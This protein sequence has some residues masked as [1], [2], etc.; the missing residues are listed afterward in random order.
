MLGLRQRGT[1]IALVV[2]AALVLSACARGSVESA[3]AEFSQEAETYLEAVAEISSD[4][5]TVVAS[6]DE[7]MQRVYATRQALLTAVADAGISGASQSALAQAEALTP[8]DEFETDHQAWIGHRVTIVDLA[9]ELDVALE[10]QDLQEALAV[11]G[12][13]LRSRSS[14]LLTAT[15][16]FCLAFAESDSSGLCVAGEGLPG[17]QYG[18]EAYEVLRR[19]TLDTLGLFSFPLD[20]SPEERAVRLN[21]VQPGIEK[22]LKDTGQKMAGLDPPSEFAD[23]NAA[24]VRFFDEQHQTAVAITAANAERD[25]TEVLRLFEESG[26]VA[27]RLNDS[28]SEEY[29]PI[30]A[31]FF[32]DD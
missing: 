11:N 17:G 2:A 31:P 10:N 6:I 14:I 24:F 1:V 7:K 13:M 22:A 28:L 23:D 32:P 29:Q 4:F 20:L 9:A 15:R 3:S 27:A 21:T 30:A 12:A 18:L 19:Y 8:P 16:E 5:N 26:V 25:N